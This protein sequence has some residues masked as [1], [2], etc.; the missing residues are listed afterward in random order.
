MKNILLRVYTLIR[1]CQPQNQM[2]PSMQTILQPHPGTIPD[3][4]DPNEGLLIHRVILQQIYAD[5][6]VICY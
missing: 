2:L 6:I 5:A 3:I 4:K 1:E